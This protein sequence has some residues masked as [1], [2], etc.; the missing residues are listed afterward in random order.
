MPHCMTPAWTC[1]Y[2]QLPS[3]I[4][5]YKNWKH[6]ISTTTLLCSTSTLSINNQM[7]IKLG[8]HIILSSIFITRQDNPWSALPPTNN[9]HT[10]C[11]PSKLSLLLSYK[12]RWL[13]IILFTLHIVIKLLKLK[14]GKTVL[15]IEVRPNCFLKNFTN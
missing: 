5:R 7:D 4:K 9:S 1:F 11:T 12:T 14:L 13:C 3:R 8:I 6:H 15:C 2:L 10:F